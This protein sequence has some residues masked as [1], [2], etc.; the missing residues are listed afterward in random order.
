MDT[1]PFE[2]Q[3]LPALNL[4]EQASD[5]Y[6]DLEMLTAKGYWWSLLVGDKVIAVC[7]CRRLWEGVGE[8]FI[9]P[10]AR[11]Q[12]HAKTFQREVRKTMNQI[13]SALKLHRLQTYAAA[14]EK[15]DRWMKALG[16]ACEG[17]LSRYTRLRQD[18]RIW[19]RLRRDE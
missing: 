4:P 15:T 6:E 13:F 3:H 16:F 12:R 18:Y 14:D 7:G 8:A 2:P 17:T 5:L 11:A 10:S 9:F 19:A 1:I